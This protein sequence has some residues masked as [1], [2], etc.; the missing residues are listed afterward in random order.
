[1]TR[2]NICYS[3][4][5]TSSHNC[6]GFGVFLSHI[7]KCLQEKIYSS[8]AFKCWNI[9]FFIVASLVANRC[10]CTKLDT[11]I[12]YISLSLQREMK[13][14]LIGRYWQRRRKVY[15]GAKCH[16]L[17]LE[18]VHIYLYNILTLWQYLMIVHLPID[19]I[20]TFSMNIACNTIGMGTQ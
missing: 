19:N 2:K 6:Y 3:T 5:R 16:I 10:Y 8:N 14:Q 11:W 15:V 13:W 18:R 12:N 4:L 9:S 20:Y 1:M 7:T 17:V